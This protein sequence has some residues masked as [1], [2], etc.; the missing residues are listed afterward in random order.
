MAE[1]LNTNPTELLENFQTAYYNQIGRR[2]QIGSEEYTLSSV[3][4]YVLTMYAALINQSY[5]NQL[6]STASGPF[7]D[8]IAERYNLSRTPE[9]YSNPWFEGL[10]WF[11]PYCSLYGRRIVK[12]GLTLTIGGHTYTNFE[13]IESATRF[14]PIRFVATEKHS[15][16][17]S[18]TE[19]L[20]ALKAIKDPADD[21]KTLFNLAYL[22]YSK[23]SGLNSCAQALSDDDFRDY[24]EQSKNLYRSGTAGAFEA[25]AKNSSEN[26][27]DARVRVQGDANFVPGNVDLYCKALSYESEW[28]YSVLPVQ[29][30]MPQLE[31]IIPESGILVIG[32]QLHVY[33]ATAAQDARS[34]SF[35]VPKAY[36]S[37]YGYLYSCKFRAVLGY[38]N[39]HVLKINEPF[40]PTMIITL[41]MKN[42]S[43]VSNDPWDYGYTPDDE[44]FTR[45]DEYKD[46]PVI[47]LESVSSMVKHD[48]GPTTYISLTTANDINIVYI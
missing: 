1:I 41:M 39:R 26:I 31:K 18:K 27:I 25:L 4:T 43:E 20:N 44:V 19:L 24:I 13:T 14:L 10:F 38:L 9:T 22:M 7:L 23:I 48:A 47:G 33:A 8:N 11:N 3:F 28:N 6:I 12:D 46:L 42:L 5:K 30:D 16:M 36:M 40:I 34:Y 17:L 2:M 15:D 21:S 32:Q 35:Y 29:I 45:F 37:D